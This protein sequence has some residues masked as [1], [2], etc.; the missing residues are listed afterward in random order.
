MSKELKVKEQIGPEIKT[1]DKVA[2]RTKSAMKVSEKALKQGIRLTGE[3]MLGAV[4]DAADPHARETARRYKE[5]LAAAAEVKRELKRMDVKTKPFRQKLR[6]RAENRLFQKAAAKRLKTRTAF[7]PLLYRRKAYEDRYREVMQ[8]R[9]KEHIRR[10]LLP[11]RRAWQKSSVGKAAKRA[12]TAIREKATKVAEKQVVKQT[13]QWIRRLA[14]AVK[15]VVTAIIA[16]GGVVFAIPLIVMLILVS[17]FPAFHAA[18][19]AAGNGMFASPFG[20]TPYT[21]TSEFGMRIDPITG[22]ITYHDGY[23]VC[24][25]TGEGSPLFAV[26]DGTIISTHDGAGSTTGYGSYVILRVDA[27]ELEEEITVLYGHLSGFV[28]RAGDQVQTGQLIG[29]EG[30][31][32]KSTGPHLHFEVRLDGEAIDGKLYWDL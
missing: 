22:Q 4:I 6:M 32:G 11:A 12:E 15:A 10:F 30:N 18:T 28:V 13:I 8:L 7:S 19:D 20:K 25:V 5:E 26:Y 31:T 23:D 24:A 21:V 27:E 14:A 2:M 1:K 3:S 9:R 29:F 17:A 16:A